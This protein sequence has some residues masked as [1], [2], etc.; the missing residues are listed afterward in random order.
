MQ[1]MQIKT[2]KVVWREG[3]FPEDVIYVVLYW[4]MVP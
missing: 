1:P 4:E 3:T 2:M